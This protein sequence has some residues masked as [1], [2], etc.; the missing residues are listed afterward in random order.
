MFK[1]FYIMHVAAAFI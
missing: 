1:L